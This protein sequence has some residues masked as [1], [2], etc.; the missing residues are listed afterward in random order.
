VK[1]SAYR[2]LLPLNPAEAP[3]CCRVVGSARKE[4]SWEP[5]WTGFGVGKGN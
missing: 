3:V 4:K 2:L 1:L 5:D